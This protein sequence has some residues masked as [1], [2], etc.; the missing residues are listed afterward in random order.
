[1]AHQDGRDGVAHKLISFILRLGEFSSAVIV[2]G[3]LANFCYDL[4]IAQSYADSRIVYTMVVAGI[5]LVYSFFVCIPFKTLF[6]GFPLDFVFFIL[7][8]V[9]FCLLET[10]TASGAC[11]GRWYNDYWGYHWGRFWRY[12]PVGSVPINRAGCS[13]WRTVLAFTFIASFTHLLSGILGIYVWRTYV[14]IPDAIQ[15][16]KHKVGSIS[17]PNEKGTRRLHNGDVETASPVAQ[18]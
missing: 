18:T 6:L 11:S 15:N 9:A 10:K 3:I 4:T 12:G 5:A 16:I 8:L 7:W 1:M 17:K 13:Q 14:H 2:L